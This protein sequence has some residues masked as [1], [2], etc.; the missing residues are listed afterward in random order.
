MALKQN[1]IVMSV[2]VLLVSFAASTFVTYLS[3][4]HAGSIAQIV[5]SAVQPGL[6]TNAV[7]LLG[8]VWIFRWFDIGL[9]APASARSLVVLWLP[10]IYLAVMA[11]AV[12][13]A[14]SPSRD[15]TIFI[16]IN[17]LLIG[18]AEEVAFRGILFQGLR[19]KLG[20]WP[21]IWITSLAFGLLHLMNYR[22]LGSLT[23]ALFQSLAAFSLGMVLLAVR[24]RTKSL[25]TG[26]V[27]HAAWDFCSMML[28]ASPMAPQNAQMAL[29]P[30]GMA[31]VLVY[32]SV[33]IGYSLFFLRNVSRTE[34]A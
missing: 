9:N 7:L 31:M 5:T 22:W 28:L 8:A 10:A 33:N 19:S 12:L 2:V 1:R 11:A 24:I 26:I 14:G 21:S 16:L 20:I 18:I 3:A 13:V 17:T 25:D 30:L 6:V 29:G 4:K 27:L 23:T 34:S 32:A 15:A